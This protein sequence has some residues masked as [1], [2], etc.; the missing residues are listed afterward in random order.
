MIYD[1]KLVAELSKELGFSIVDSSQTSVDIKIF[2]DAILV[3]QN[4]DEQTDSL[5]GFSGTPWHEH[6]VLMFSGSDG[7][8]T[9]LAYIDVLSEIKLGKVLVCELFNH[10]VLKDRYLVHK[11][12]IDEFEY[13]QSGD[14]IRIRQYINDSL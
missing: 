4:I 13:M 14:E 11:N 2:E 6:G 9:E 7:C 1:L 3:F 8:Y 5:I 12:H 10:G